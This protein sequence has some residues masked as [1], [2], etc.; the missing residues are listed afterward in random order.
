MP[1]FLFR[2]SL[3]MAFAL[4]V[5]SAAADEPIERDVWNQTLTLHIARDS[6]ER[7]LDQVSRQLNLPIELNGPA[8]QIEGVTK[9]AAL[10]VEFQAVPLRTALWIIAAKMGR[11]VIVRTLRN[12]AGRVIGVEFTTWWGIEPSRRV[13]EFSEADAELLCSLLTASNDREIENVLENL[14][15]MGVL[16]A[17]AI[18]RLHALAAD[19]S[20]Q[21]LRHSVA[22]AIREIEAAI[23][24]D[25]E[26]AE[27]LALA[28]APA[29]R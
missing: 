29:Q 6:A 27:Q 24:A 23:A 12:K 2:C 4:T 13:A 20:E 17:G 21:H 5:L 11:K 28:A 10:R 1:S 18:D 22:H 15:Q 25:E 26:F 7:I 8:L 3:T 16:A 19:V 14:A 9:N